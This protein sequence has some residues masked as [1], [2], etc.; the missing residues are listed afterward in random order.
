MYLEFDI[1]KKLKCVVT[2]KNG[3]SNKEWLQRD[4]INEAM[5]D[6]DCVAIASR[7]R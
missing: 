7:L 1:Y 6:F 2:I 5:Y 4:K 3:D